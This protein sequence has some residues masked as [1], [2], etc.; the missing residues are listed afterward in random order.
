MFNPQKL[1][2]ISYITGIIDVIKQNIFT[3]IILVGFNI[4]N[5]DFTEIRHYIGPSIF[6]FIFILTFIHR[7]L[8]IKVTRYWIENDQ[9][10]VTSG[11]LNKKRKE[12]NL[13]RIQSLDT[14]QGLINQIVGGVSLQIKTPSDGI[15]LATIT[16]KQS[17][18]IEQTIRMRQKELNNDTQ[19]Y[20]INDEADENELKTEQ[21]NASTSVT[22]SNSEHVFNMSLTSLILMAMTSGAI[23]VA[24]LCRFA[25]S[26]CISRYYPLG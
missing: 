22:E 10:I 4:W 19:E 25:N 15:E 7:F 18:F 12:L 20:S 16:K 24:F 8:E 13:S 2:P 5:F 6:L 26:R 21:Y 23:G 3:F 17:E 1:H 11:W 14:T 9:F